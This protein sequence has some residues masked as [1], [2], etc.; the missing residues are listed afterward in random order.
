MK[1]TMKEVV[2]GFSVS[3]IGARISIIAYDK[4]ARILLNFKEN[5]DFQNVVR[6][7]EK[8]D[9]S[10]NT[11]RRLDLALLTVQSEIFS[12]KAGRRQVGLG[13]LYELLES[14][15]VLT[16]LFVHLGS[17]C[18]TNCFKWGHTIHFI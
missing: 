4:D 9:K 2:N 7:I 6:K 16:Q 18:S 13:I 3:E 8:L 17:S 15:L 14:L 12:M 1:D 5:V 10:E 11:E